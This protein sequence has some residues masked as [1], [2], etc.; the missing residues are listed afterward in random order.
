MIDP[1]EEA[2]EKLSKYRP[3][4]SSVR[5]NSAPN[6][7]HEPRRK[8]KSVEKDQE[9]GSKDALTEKRMMYVVYSFI[10]H[11]QQRNGTTTGLTFFGAL[12]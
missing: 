2:E 1:F 6:S 7:K 12:F 10:P 5:T 9:G 8:S 3:R 4:A 11:H